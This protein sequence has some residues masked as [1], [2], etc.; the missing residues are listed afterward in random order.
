MG[1]AVRRT[2]DPAQTYRLTNSPVYFLSL[3]F[4]LSLYN[5]FGPD[6]GISVGVL[7][8][9]EVVWNRNLGFSSSGPLRPAPPSRFFMVRPENL[10]NIQV[11]TAAPHHYPAWAVPGVRRIYRFPDTSTRWGCDERQE[12]VA[13][14]GGLTCPPSV[15]RPSCSRRPP[16]PSPLGSIGRD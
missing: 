13:A 14:L 3:S 5:C 8:L 10:G 2:D 12:L 6:L 1:T 9:P 15:A 11:P 4:S 16:H 7:T